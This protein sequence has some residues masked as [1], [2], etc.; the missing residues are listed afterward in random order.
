MRIGKTGSPNGLH[1]ELNSCEAAMQTDESA[2]EDR[3]GLCPD[4]SATETTASPSRPPSRQSRRAAL[5]STI[6]GEMVPRLL[7][8]C[9]T[10]G[11]EQGGAGCTCE[12]ADAGDVEELARLLVAHG[13]EMARAFVEAVRR[14]GVPYERICVGLLA[15]AARRLAEQWEHRDFGK[16]ELKLGQDGLLTVLREIGNA[17]R[18]DRN[19]THDD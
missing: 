17:A 9:R 3:A 18:A 12:T 14:R 1:S 11:P 16:S 4:Q 6:E 5:I 10:A 7:M 8:L 15:P 19:V 13:P 2:P